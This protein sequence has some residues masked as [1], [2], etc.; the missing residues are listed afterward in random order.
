[1]GTRSFSDPTEFVPPVGQIQPFTTRKCISLQRGNEMKNAFVWRV[2]L[3]FGY[4]L[5]HVRHFFRLMW[6]RGIPR[7]HMWCRVVQPKYAVFYSFFKHTHHCKKLCI[8]TKWA[9]NLIMFCPYGHY[10]LTWWHA[11]SPHMWHPT[12]D[13]ADDVAS[14]DVEN[15]HSAH[16][17]PALPRHMPRHWW[18][19]TSLVRC[20]VTTLGYSDHKYQKLLNLV[21]IWW[22]Y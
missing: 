1:M 20:H 18:G 7:H 17:I 15:L 10:T 14:R 5:H 2:A 13:V 22:R 6:W 12:S 9:P 11:K 21:P 3:R 4:L 16:D 19:D 8:F